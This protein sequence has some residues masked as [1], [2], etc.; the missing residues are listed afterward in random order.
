MVATSVYIGHLEEAFPDAAELI[1]CYTAWQQEERPTRD[2][3]S[4]ADSDRSLRWQK[5]HAAAEGAG[6]AWLSNPLQQTFQFRLH[7]GAA[8][9]GRSVP[10]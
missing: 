8:T 10:A 2:G 1:E 7:E 3:Y 4:Y 9:T 6:R 5:A